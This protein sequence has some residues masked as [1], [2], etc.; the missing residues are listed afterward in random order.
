M[1]DKECYKNKSVWVR[2]LYMLLFIF[3][4]NIAKFVTMA[5]VFLQFLVVLFTGQANENLLTFGKSLSVYQ[6]QILRFI[7]YNSENQPFPI[8]EWPQ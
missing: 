5:V 2:G 3:L 7:T 6:Y 1:S 4:L 8:G